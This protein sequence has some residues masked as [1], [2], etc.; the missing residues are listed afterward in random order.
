MCGHQGLHGHGVLLHQV[1]DAGIGVDHQLIGEAAPAPAIEMILEN[2]ALP[3][4]P[5]LVHERHA[6][7][8][9]G[10]QHLLGGDDLELI[11]VYVETE[12]FERDL[13]D[14]IVGARQCLEIPVGTLEQKV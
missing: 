9:I 10:I 11:G 13:L 3:E 1:G 5:M 8:R 7:R 12:I 14:G 4:G 6:H 2:E